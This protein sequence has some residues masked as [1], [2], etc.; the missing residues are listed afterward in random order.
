MPYTVLV[1]PRTRKKAKE[2]IVLP[3]LSDVSE[4]DTELSGEE[5]TAEEPIVE[6][7]TV[8]DDDVAI[9]DEE[10]EEVETDTALVPYDPLQRY[11]AEIRRYPLLTPEEEHELAVRYKEHGEVEAAYRLVTAKSRNKIQFDLA[12]AIA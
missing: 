1:M 5:E 6:L 4:T 9:E 2:E 3:S 11:L 10:K 12:V 8:S 7:E